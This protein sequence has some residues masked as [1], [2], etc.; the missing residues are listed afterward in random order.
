MLNNRTVRQFLPGYV[1]SGLGDG[2]AVVAVSWFAIELAPSTDRAVWVAAAAAAYTL[3]AAAGAVLLGRFLRGRDPARLVGWDAILRAC[4]LGAIPIAYAFDALSIGLYVVLLAMSSVLHSWGQAGLFTLL[5]RL[6]PEKDR[7]A[8]NALLSTVG[9]CTTIG[10]P[11]IAAPLIAVSGPAVVLAV[12]AATFA[13]LAATFLLFVRVPPAP[14]DSVEAGTR[15]SGFS[16]VRRSPSLLGLLSLSF[17]FFFLFGT[18][19]VALPLRVSDDLLGSATLLAAYYTAFGIGAVVGGIAAGYLRSLRLWPTAIGIVIAVGIAMLPLGLDVP[20]AFAIAAFALVGMLWPPYWSL[21]T[22]LVQASVS[23]ALLP[24]VLAASSSVRV[25]AVPLG[26]AMGGPL[27][28]ALGAGGGLRFIAG[29]VIGLGV[30]AAIA[31][32]AHTL[33]RRC[34]K[35]NVAETS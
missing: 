27:V 18:V 10:G 5:A 16:I 14:L 34:R 28:V 12:D 21:S 23:S 8:G 29:S 33:T 26:T 31:A 1:L 15:R 32:S 4:A 9:A 35:A 2:M 24:S 13:V 7:L 19:Y 3:P 17:G 25:L 6:L 22:T 30:V 11:A 20:N